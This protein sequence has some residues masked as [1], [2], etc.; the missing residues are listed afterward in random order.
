VF[1]DMTAQ[2]VANEPA[3]RAAPRVFV[4]HY[5]DGQRFDPDNSDG[6]QNAIR[7]ALAAGRRCHFVLAAVPN[8]TEAAE[9]L[10]YKGIAVH[11]YDPSVPIADIPLHHPLPP[12][13]AI[14]APL[15]PPPAATGPPSLAP[16]SH[17]L[18]NIVLV[19]AGE[20]ALQREGWGGLPS[21][22]PFPPSPFPHFF[23]SRGTAPHRTPTRAQCWGLSLLA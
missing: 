16:T 6:T 8:Y 14:L 12:A 21:P 7:Y 10:H 15:P 19:I 22:P 18:F 20:L 1:T 2:A 9:N 11:K 5:G 4:L 13:P 23:F 17:G 3:V